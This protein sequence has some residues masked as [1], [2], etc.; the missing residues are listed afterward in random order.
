MYCIVTV[1]RLSKLPHLF[2][3]TGLNTLNSTNSSK[4]MEIILSPGRP[5]KSMYKG[6][7]LLEVAT[8]GSAEREP[9]LD[10][11]KFCYLTTSEWHPMMHFSRSIAQY[12]SRGRF[13]R[14][15]RSFSRRLFSHLC[16]S[17]SKK[18]ALFCYLT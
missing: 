16:S 5:V 6:C 7:H 15:I 8:P 4:C 13:H 18:I 9:K 14:E 2:L 3:R 17:K 1:T 10:Q 11:R 12:R